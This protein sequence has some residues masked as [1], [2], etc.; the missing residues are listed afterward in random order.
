MQNNIST[1][2]CLS[3]QVYDINSEEYKK[4]LKLYQKN[5]YKQNKWKY[6]NKELER[7]KRLYYHKKELT[8]FMN[9]LLN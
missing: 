4:Q 7:R 5:Y 2:I 3:Q 8:E 1:A 6:R 9:I